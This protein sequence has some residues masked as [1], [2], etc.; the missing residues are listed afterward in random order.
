M[1]QSEIPAK[2]G[3][4]WASEEVLGEWRDPIISKVER[5]GG[6][7]ECQVSNGKSWY[8]QKD[9][10]NWRFWSEVVVPPSV[11]SLNEAEALR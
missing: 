4:Y 1:W 6:I 2:P 7:V 11:E 5:M 8:R 9:V 3:R 10:P